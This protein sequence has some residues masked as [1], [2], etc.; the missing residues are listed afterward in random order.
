LACGCLPAEE[1]AVAVVDAEYE[2]TAADAKFYYERAA[3]AGEGPVGG[4]VEAKV[5]EIVEAAVLGKILELEAEARGYADDAD[6]RRQLEEIRNQKL[7]DY[8]FARLEAAVRV[9]PAEVL[10]F[11]E[12][13]RTRRRYSFILT[14]SPE[15]AEEA[16][17][18][19]AAGMPWARAVEEFSVFEAYAGPGGAWECPMEYTADEAAQALFGLQLGEYT[20]PVK[21][22]GDYKWQIYR[23]DKEV[24]GSS[25]SYAE[26]AADAELFLTRRK[27]YERFAELSRGWRKAVPIV[28]NEE[29]WRDI[30][31]RPCE[32]LWAD[33]PG[34]G[35]V[36]AEVAGIPV[37][38]DDVWNVVQKFFGLPPAAVEELRGNNPRRYESVW[39]AYLRELE[40]LA[41]LRHQALR[42]GVDRLPSFRREMASRRAELLLEALYRDEFAPTIPAPS[43]E[44]VR[45]YYEAHRDLFYYPERVEV[46]LVAMPERGAFERFH[47]EIKAGADLVI[48]GE[49]RNRAR[50]KAETESSEPPPAVPPER[51]EWLGVVAVTADPKHPNSPPDPPL[52]AE[53]RPRLFPVGG[54]NVLSPVF[55]LRDGRW[56]FYA[57][58]YHAPAVQLGLDDAEV[59]YFCRQAVFEE[60]A[61]SPAVSAAADEWL[62]SLR[63]RHDVVID[64]AAV[65]RLA[66]E[67]REAAPVR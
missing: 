24:Y 33:Y 49:A 54:L 65:A 32:E 16:Y 20:R 64:A 19:L 31:S 34:R 3:A 59:A 44:E 14:E 57:P 52:A 9:T 5:R 12:K 67:L 36:L 15:R 29:L 55:R 22:P 1:E 56:A 2:I 41:L 50:E 61:R 23:Y 8:M 26:A 30:L 25:A 6:I 60:T 13:S 45:A 58:I 35:L 51:R 27:A 63:A 66:A 48:S 4:D 40:D 46:Y 39:D 42:E 28:R 10:A 53:L 7:L 11:Y 37:Y 47:G 43:E 18:A 62:A 17:A 21:V 38:Y